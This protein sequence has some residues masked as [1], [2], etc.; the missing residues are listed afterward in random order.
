MNLDRIRSILEL[1]ALAHRFTR[2]FTRLTCGNK[3]GAQGDGHGHAHHKATSLGADDL[4][5][6]HAG[7]MFGQG[8]N[9]G[10]QRLGIAKERR[11]VLKDDSGLGIVGDIDDMRFEVVHGMTF[12]GLPG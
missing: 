3:A 6:S 10:L 12:Q 9:H 11:D 1:V 2:Q 5:D 8:I 4:G 7:K